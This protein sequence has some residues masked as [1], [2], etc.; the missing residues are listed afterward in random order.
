MVPSA[1]ALDTVTTELIAEK[2]YAFQKCFWFTK[3]SYGKFYTRFFNGHL[4]VKEQFCAN[5]KRR[6]RS[7]LDDTLTLYHVI[8][9]IYITQIGTN[10]NFRKW[11]FNCFCVFV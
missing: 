9:Y 1:N 11:T 2:I 7:E 8:T 4:G 5:D 6:L 10:R 3:L